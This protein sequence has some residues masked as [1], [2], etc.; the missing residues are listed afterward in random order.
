M[1]SDFFAAGSFLQM[2]R[3]SSN[4]RTGPL[5]NVGNENERMGSGTIKG[6]QTFSNR[7][8]Y[9]RLSCHSMKVSG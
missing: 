5:G 1:T 6:V 2:A 7:D 9:N 3:A 8:K 4:M